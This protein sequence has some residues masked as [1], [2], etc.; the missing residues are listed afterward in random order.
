MH[1]TDERHLRRAIELADRAGREGNHPFG[2][3]IAAGTSV[4]AEGR[5]AVVTTGNVL[6]HAETDAIEAAVSAGHAA[7]LIG[8]TIYASG[9]PCPMCAGA[10]VW[11]GITRVVYA[12]AEP[13]FAP[14]IGRTPRFGELRCADV[15]RAADSSITVDGPALGEDG[16]APFRG[17]VRGY[18]AA[19]G[20]EIADDHAGD[21]V[22]GR[23]IVAGDD[24]LGADGGAESHDH[25]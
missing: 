18:R 20:V 25:Q 10:I 23:L 6:T 1:R 15:I 13:D 4:I 12:A 11:A 14:I 22:Q 7:A 16:L 17:Y 3:V 19:S 5:N 24:D 9:E 8:A 21:L 2:A